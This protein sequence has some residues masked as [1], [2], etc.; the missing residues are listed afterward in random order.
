MI[1]IERLGS[2]LGAIDCLPEVAEI[3][4]VSK[5]SLREKKTDKN[6]VGQK[7]KPDSLTKGASM[8]QKGCGPSSGDVKLAVLDGKT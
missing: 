7:R 4:L 8:T 1:M 6:F 3:I 5:R 2:R